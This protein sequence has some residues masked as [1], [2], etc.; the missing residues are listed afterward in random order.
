MKIE[1]SYSELEFL[2]IY[3]SEHCDSRITYNN[4]SFQ[5]YFYNRDDLDIFL[6]VEGTFNGEKNET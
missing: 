4:P 3:L 1:C 2:R 6:K 5:A